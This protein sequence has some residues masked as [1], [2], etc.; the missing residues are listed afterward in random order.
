MG[1]F[2]SD[3]PQQRD[4]FNDLNLTMKEREAIALGNLPPTYDAVMKFRKMQ[5]A[6]DIN[7]TVQKPAPTGQHQIANQRAQGLGRTEQLLKAA[8]AMQQQRKA[9]QDKGVIRG[10]LGW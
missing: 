9:I 1:W 6:P 10:I 5:T 8:E 3:T 4:P 7:A 2:G